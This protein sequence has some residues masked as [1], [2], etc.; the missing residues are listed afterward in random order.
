MENED[1][2]HEERGNHGADG[3][4]RVGREQYTRLAVPFP[5]VPRPKRGEE[6]KRGGIKGHGAEKRRAGCVSAR[7]KP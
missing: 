7:G 6:D 3:P 4:F 2:E 1:A 5:Y